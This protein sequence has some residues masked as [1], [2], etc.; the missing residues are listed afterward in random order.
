MLAPW[1]YRHNYVGDVRLNPSSRFLACGL[2]RPSG[3]LPFLPKHYNPRSLAERMEVRSLNARFVAVMVAVLLCGCAGKQQQPASAQNQNRRGAAARDVAI[4]VGVAQAKRQDVPVFLSGLGTV[5][6]YNTVVVKSRVD[7]AIMKINFT[8][9]QHVRKG[10]VLAEIDPRPYEVQLETAQGNLARDQALLNTSKVNLQRNEQ[11]AQAGVVAVQQLDAQRAETGQYQGT[12]EADTAAINSAKL[13]LTYAKI[14]APIDGR[15]GLRQIDIGNIVHATDQNGLCTITQLQPIAVIF[16]LPED[17]AQQVRNR[18]RSGSMMA[19]AFSRD[20][21]QSIAQGRLETIDNQIDTTTG[22]VRLKAIFSNQKEE[23]WPNEFVNIHLQLQTE[24]NAIVIPS[25]ALQRGPQGTFVFV[26]GQDNTAQVRPV[27]VKLT[28]GLT[29]LI[30]SGIAE[31]D[32]VVTDGQERLQANAKV[33]PRTPQPRNA[34]QGA[35]GNQPI[36]SGPGA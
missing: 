23:L 35:P 28:Q 15:V 19:D 9:G 10:E 21:T 12:V 34:Q 17:S 32:R 31:G 33:D 8:E 26:V 6:A 7:G 14:T 4:P 16:T 1:K 30:A 2:E 24:R 13:N 5:T 3:Y 22:T 11:L 27:E 18:L 20:D 36:G 29:S 25:S